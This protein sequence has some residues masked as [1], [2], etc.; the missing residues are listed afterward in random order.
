MSRYLRVLSISW[1]LGGS[2][3][4][5]QVN[6]GTISGIVQD[7]S[8]AAIPA[9]AVTV[10]NLDTGTARSLITDSLSSKRD[11]PDVLA[12]EKVQIR[13]PRVG[14]NIVEVL[15]GPI[16]CDTERIDQIGPQYIAQLNRG[17][18]SAGNVLLIRNGTAVDVGYHIRIVIKSVSDEESHFFADRMIDAS[19]EIIFIGH[20]ERRGK[21]N[22]GAISEVGGGQPG[23][24]SLEEGQ[25]R[26]HG[27]V[28]VDMAD[29]AADHRAESLL[30]VAKL[31]GCRNDTQRHISLQGGS[32]RY[33]GPDIG[34]IALPQPFVVAEEEG[35]IFLDGPA[36]SASKLVASKRSYRAGPAVTFLVKIT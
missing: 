6:T 24:G 15:V 30:L 5:A 32:G 22:S 23:G 17:I 2:V 31:P 9:V 26:L 1:I 20:L 25:V 28:D 34:S 10:R 29:A 18:L 16:V 12:G 36:Q 13:R 11:R 35:F 21:E 3:I 7:E 14:H 27:R 4:F 8:G 19:H 33:F